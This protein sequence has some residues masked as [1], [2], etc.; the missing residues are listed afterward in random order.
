MTRAHAAKMIT[1]ALG[2]NYNQEGAIAVTQAEALTMIQRLKQFTNTLYP[3]PDEER[4]YDPATLT[5]SPAENMILGV[6]QPPPFIV[7]FNDMSYE[8]PKNGYESV[9]TPQ[10]SL[11]GFT[12]KQIGKE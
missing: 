5:L 10:F 2:R 9:T 7:S 3:C 4:Y 1:N 12:K 11:E 8:S 6:E